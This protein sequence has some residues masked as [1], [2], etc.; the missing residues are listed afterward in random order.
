[1]SFFESVEPIRYAGPDSDDPFTF[2]W[3]DADRVVA[4]EQLRDRLFLDRRRMAGAQT[5][6][7]LSGQA[8]LAA[9]HR[10]S[11]CARPWSTDR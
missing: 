5:A 7:L 2:R 6:G 3:Y 11:R 8:T 1:M 9:R 10:P 4:G